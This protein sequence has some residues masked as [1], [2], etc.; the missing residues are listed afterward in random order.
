MQYTILNT[1][2]KAETFDG[3]PSLSD[4][5]KAVGGCIETIPMFTSYRGKPC[6]AYCNEEGKLNGLPFNFEATE[7]WVQ[8][9]VDNGAMNVTDV[10][11]GDI[12]TGTKTELATL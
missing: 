12:V 1:K 2:G 10:L 7:L 6:V 8:N 4:L 5:Q 11:L 9:A 3:K